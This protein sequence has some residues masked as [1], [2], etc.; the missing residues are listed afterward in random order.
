MLFSNAEQSPKMQRAHGKAT[1][2]F[3]FSL[4]VYE[5]L[6][7]GLY[8]LKGLLFVFYQINEKKR[9]DLCPKQVSLQIH[10]DV[11]PDELRS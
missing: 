11:F 3:L 1:L 2:Y 9:L 6:L 4:Y 7:I 10:H 8:Q 5:G